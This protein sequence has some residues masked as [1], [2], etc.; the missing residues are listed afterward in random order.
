[1]HAANQKKDQPN[2]PPCAKI[3]SNCNSCTPRSRKP[4][5][6]EHRP[7]AMSCPP[8]QG[9]RRTAAPAQRGAASCAGTS[10]SSPPNSRRPQSQAQG[11]QAQMQALRAN[12]GQ[13]AA[14]GQ[15]SP[16]AQAGSRGAL[17]SGPV[18]NSEQ[19]MTAACIN[20]LRAID[21][22]KQQ[23]A[24]ENQKPASALI[25]AADL[26]PYLQERYA[27][28]V[29][30]GRRLYAQP[31]RPSRR[32]ATSPATPSRDDTGRYFCFPFRPFAIKVY[33]IHE[34]H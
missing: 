1:M 24:L 27:A 22:A 9:Q 2:W 12:P 17:R 5:Q 32:S 10:S 14:P 30:G 8:A 7:R 16:A 31:G 34:R 15:P 11:A 6:T 25:T 26:A 29:P 13:P 33:S 28:G 23:W 19:A 4:R 20:N 21:G 3:A 18:T